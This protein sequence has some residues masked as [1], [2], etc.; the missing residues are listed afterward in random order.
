M[1]CA[2]KARKKRGSNCAESERGG[3]VVKAEIAESGADLVYEISGNPA[4]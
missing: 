2:A 4:H 1:R 3:G